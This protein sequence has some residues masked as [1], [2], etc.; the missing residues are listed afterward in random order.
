MLK[1][2]NL[3]LFQIR[4][5]EKQEDMRCKI[6]GMEASTWKQLH[7]HMMDHTNER[8]FKCEECGKGF[9]EMQ[10]LRRHMITHTGVKAH[11][12]KHCGK[13]F[14]L[15]HNMKAHEKIH[16]GQGHKC[17]YCGICYSQAP[18]LREHEKLHVL[19]NHVVTSDPEVLAK[20]TFSKTR[21]RPN[22]SRLGSAAKTKQ[23][24]EN[25]TTKVAQS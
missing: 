8:P 7:I 19:E 21:G 16:V 18:N 3:F 4:A 12:C 17:R 22:I 6:C 23:G 20:Q 2:P 11:V 9:K 25:V 24:K 5:I 1:I 10:K 13:S 14:G 15:R